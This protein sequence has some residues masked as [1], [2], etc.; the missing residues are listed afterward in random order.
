MHD[1]FSTQ[2]LRLF[3][4]IKNDY[5][6]WSQ[7]ILPQN[8][9]KR[10]GSQCI[11]KVNPSSEEL[12]N[13]PVLEPVAAREQCLTSCLPV[14][15]MPPE[16]LCWSTPQ[17]ILKTCSSQFA[18]TTPKAFLVLQ[19]KKKQLKLHYKASDKYYCLQVHR[20]E[21]FKK[22]ARPV[23]LI[24]CNS[25]RKQDEFWVSCENVSWNHQNNLLSKL[26]F[27]SSK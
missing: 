7:A 13:Q 27:P 17:I 18:K 6:S 20:N 5:A 14:F 23:W 19:V 24:S 4:L 1:F 15:K 16:F 12:R 2:Y 21:S 26:S 25:T 10:E 9:E 22:I 3:F 11:W 8:L